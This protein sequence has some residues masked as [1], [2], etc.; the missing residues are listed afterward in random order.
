M[1]APLPF[2]VANGLPAV[3]ELTP[4]QRE[5]LNG[6]LAYHA[7]ANPGSRISA[8][9]AV[10]DIAQVPA[11]NDETTIDGSATATAT[12]VGTVVVTS[13][14]TG[15]NA[16]EE[17]RRA[18][19]L[20]HQDATPATTR[21]PAPSSAARAVYS[22][23]ERKSPGTLDTV[24]EAIMTRRERAIDSKLPRF[25]DGLLGARETT[26]GWHLA[27]E[28]PKSDAIPA[29]LFGIHW[30]QTGGAERWAVESVQLATAAGLLPIIVTDQ[31]SV[32]PWLTR[33]ELD[34]ALIIPLS[35]TGHDHPVDLSLVRAIL[36]NYDVRGIVLHHSQYLY[37]ALPWVK[38][39]R[40]DIPVVDSLHI[41]EYLG[42]GYPG[43]AARL[44]EF[45]D[46]HHVIS[47]QLVE[48]L[49][50]VQGVDPAK[51]ELAP[52]TDLTVDEL[53]DFSPRVSNSPLT[54]AFVGR[55]SRQKRPD[56]FLGLVR[57]LQRR[58]LPFRAILHGD[59]EMRDIVAE[60]LERLGLTAAI[61]QRFEDTPVAETLADSDLLVVTS[62]N[63]GLTLT[64][65]EAIAAGIPVISTDVG[66]QRTIVT[67]DALFPRPARRF[68]RESAKLIQRIEASEP[69]RE[70]LWSEQ[71]NAVAEFSKLPTAHHFMKE[72][73]TTWQA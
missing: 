33:P 37:Q 58:S 71:R 50:S 3:T 56:V 5:Q 48:W 18:I 20:A 14:A 66:S 41:V 54:V 61:E 15:R 51:L 43:L 1:T 52:L 30:L 25:P 35:F 28:N 49:S 31:N 29:V 11:F 8:E 46:T 45:I 39:H 57:E 68:I 62:V 24:R 38:H 27:P 69:L 26:A 6:A 73:F 34:G 63:E 53:S 72:L 7:L 9:V 12:P 44:D 65:F 23:L 70:Q 22:F 60:L 10:G 21:P 36:E 64:T 2:T 19:R 40:P 59:G 17:V 32:H 4:Q 47:P 42:G 55:L 16:T 13:T 67:G